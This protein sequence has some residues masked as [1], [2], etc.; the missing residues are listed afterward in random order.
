MLRLAPINPRSGVPKQKQANKKQQ[1]QQQ[2]QLWSLHLN[3]LK[4]SGS[5]PISCELISAL[6]LWAGKTILNM[7]RYYLAM[8][9][10]SYRASSLC[11]SPLQNSFT[12]SITYAENSTMRISCLMELSSYLTIQGFCVA[13]RDFSHP[14]VWQQALPWV[15]SWQKEAANVCC[16]PTCPWYSGRERVYVWA[17]TRFF[18]LT[19]KWN[20][21][22]EVFNHT[23]LFCFSS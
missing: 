19:W 10:S 6:A 2:K 9:G 17:V 5:V 21:V 1:Q 18:L 11:I 12:I 15:P 8:F 7:D 22:K 4:I 13:Q 20:K 3:P 23:L 16:H 14:I